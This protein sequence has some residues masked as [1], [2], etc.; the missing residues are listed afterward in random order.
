MSSD[1]LEGR[2]VSTRGNALARDYIIDELKM[3]G[4]P[5]NVQEFQLSNKKQAGINIIT[6]VKGSEDSKKVIVI[7]AHYDH[8]GIRDNNETKN[9]SVDVIYNGADD[10]ASGTSTLLEMAIYFAKNKPKHNIILVATDAEESGLQG[11][12]YFVDNYEQLDQVV[13][14]I[15]MDMISVSHTN[16]L[17][18]CG[19]IHTESL[20]NFFQ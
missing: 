6:E 2:K 15:N 10:N 3:S 8:V 14:N 4:L 20:A 9:D 5:I 1:S 7:T 17:N 18:V 11:A 12:S 13:L 19:T 16:Q